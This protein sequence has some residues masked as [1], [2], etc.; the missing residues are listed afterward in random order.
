MKPI[1]IYKSKS[2]YT[3][4]YAQ[5]LG[6]ALACEVREA[7]GLQ[8]A[9]LEAYN[10]IIYGGGLYACRI[11]GLELITN[12]WAQLCGKQLV[13]W[14]TGSNPGRESDVKALAETNFSPEQLEKVHFFYLR[15]GFDFAKLDGGGKFLMRMLKL[16][17]KATKNRTEDEEGL[18]QAYTTPENHV[19]MENLEPLLACVRSLA[20]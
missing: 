6:K 17:L 12:N 9:E 1:V 18:L 14:A 8:P 5:M 10:P 20:E 3:K 7:A 15:G 16:K 4:D 13:V 11:N 2:G 19:S